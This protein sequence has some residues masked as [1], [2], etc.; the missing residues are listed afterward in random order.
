MASGILLPVRYLFVFK[1][2]T[3]ESICFT[4]LMIAGNAYFL[5]TWHTADALYVK[6]EEIGFRS[7]LSK[8][9]AYKAIPADTREIEI[10]LGN[11]WYSRKFRL[12]LISIDTKGLRHFP[13]ARPESLSSPQPLVSLPSFF[14]RLKSAVIPAPIPVI[15]QPILQNL[16]YSI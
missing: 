9:S 10:K 13:Y 1:K 14:K 7:R 11:I 4:N 5:L 3:F 6:A 2:P 8:G 15:E 12:R 16:S